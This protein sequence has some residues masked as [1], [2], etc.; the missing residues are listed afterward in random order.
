[1]STGA[2]A[3]LIHIGAK[4]AHA[5]G[6]PSPY[7]EDHRPRRSR[8]YWLKQI[9]QANEQARRWACDVRQVAN[10]ISHQMSD[11]VLPHCW[12]MPDT[13]DRV[14]C[15]IDKRCMEQSAHSATGKQP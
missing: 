1:M 11:S 5:T 7:G 6:M 2:Y 15:R 14:K 8:A 4:M 3:Q 9:E 10:V 13:C 12:Q